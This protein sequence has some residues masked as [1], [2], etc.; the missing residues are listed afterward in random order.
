M[1]SIPFG[2]AIRRFFSA[3]EAFNA[4]SPTNR[5]KRCVNYFDQ[6]LTAAIDDVW[7]AWFRCPASQYE[8]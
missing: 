1:L 2:P 3:P 5:S 7:A 8:F 4:A 6:S